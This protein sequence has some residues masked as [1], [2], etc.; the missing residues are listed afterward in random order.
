MRAVHRLFVATC[1]IVALLGTVHVAVA[2]STTATPTTFHACQDHALIC[3]R[4]RL[5]A[6]STDLAVNT[7]LPYSI[8]TLEFAKAHGWKLKPVKG[9]DGKALL[10]VYVAEGVTVSLGGLQ[11]QAELVVAPSESFGSEMPRF[12]G[13]LGFDF[14]KDDILRIGFPHHRLQ[15]RDAGSVDAT[16]RLP[17]TLQMITFGHNGPRS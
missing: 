3:V 17:G 14:F 4:G 9:A 2:A 12:N 5:G 1:A 6:T 11:R 7:G 8:A 15:T 16:T 10:N 13:A